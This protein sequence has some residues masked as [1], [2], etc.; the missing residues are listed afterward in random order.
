MVQEAF[1]NME[2]H[3][4]AVRSSFVARRLAQGAGQAS[5]CLDKIIICVSDDG[6]G[7]QSPDTQGLGMMSMHRRAAALGAKL[8]FISESG[9][10]L[11]VR[12]EINISKI[13]VSEVAK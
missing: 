6:V 8:D 2:K 11:M 7:I 9:N 3:S 10:G 1:T 4:K 12:I 13:P 5:P